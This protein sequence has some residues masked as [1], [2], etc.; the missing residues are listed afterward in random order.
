MSDFTPANALICVDWEGS[1]M[2]LNVPLYY[3][4][5][6]HKAYIWHGAACSMYQEG[7][8]IRCDPTEVFGG[9]KYSN[10]AYQAL[11]G[12]DELSQRKRLSMFSSC[13]IE[14]NML[15]KNDA[16]KWVFEMNGQ[17]DDSA[18]TCSESDIT[19]C[20]GSFSDPI[21][22]SSDTSLCTQSERAPQ[23]YGK[24]VESLAKMLK[25]GT[26]PVL[27]LA[28]AFKA[29]MDGGLKCGKDNLPELPENSESTYGIMSYNNSGGLAL[30]QEVFPAASCRSDL[31]ASL[32]VTVN[33][34]VTCEGKSA[35]R[36]VLNAVGDDSSIAVGSIDVSDASMN[37]PRVGLALVLLCLAG[38]GL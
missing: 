29:I 6:V 15:R 16:D 19:A 24:Y 9:D 5:S 2:S 23:N 3:W 10:Q 33:D 26:N 1:P 21:K 18:G 34:T 20:T 35:L 7:K 8:P 12:D 14:V 32:E 17:V 11:Q 28:P 22:V 37:V 31:G 30:L 27:S 38:L 13:E 4:N 25:D 36:R